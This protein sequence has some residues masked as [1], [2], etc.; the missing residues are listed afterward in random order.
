MASFGLTL[1]FTFRIISASYDGAK[2]SAGKLLRFVAYSA[3]PFALV[4]AVLSIVTHG[5]SPS[6]STL[7]FFNFFG[8]KFAVI[9][10]F[11]LLFVF[12]IFA[13]IKDFM[14][15]CQLQEKKEEHHDR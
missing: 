11:V 2:T 13:S 12:I 14:N 4:N 8:S 5:L 9:S 10:V 6:F 7:L 3:T 1:F 15:D